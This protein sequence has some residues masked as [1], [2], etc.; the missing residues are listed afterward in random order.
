MHTLIVARMDPTDEPAVA[1]LFEKSDRTDLPHL[2]GAT[3]RTLFTYHGLYFHLVESGDDMPARLRAMREDPLYAE[4][5]DG[6]A[7]HITPYSP[8]WREPGDAMA[9]TFYSW[10]PSD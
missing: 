8:T 3:R 6:L 7:A 10:T 2:I 4:L 5:N 9:T 1:A